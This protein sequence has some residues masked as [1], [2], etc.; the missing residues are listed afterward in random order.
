MSRPL[1]SIALV[2]GLSLAGPAQAETVTAA[3]AANFTAVAETLAE[4]F[5]EQTSHEVVLS[6]GS[7]GQLYAQIANAA[8]FDVFLAADE[9]RPGQAIAEGYA[10]AGTD[11]V[12]AVGRLV[13]YSPTI[14][15]EVGHTALE[16]DFQHLAIADPVAA[17]YGTAAVQV[18]EG[19]GLADTIAD[20]I[21][22]GENISQALQF[23]ESGN[24]ELGFVAASQVVGKP[25]QWMVPETLHAPIAQRAVLLEA[26]ADSQAAMAF[27]D[28]LQSPEGIT[29]IEAAGYGVP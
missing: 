21:V 4:R 18:L 13:L 16:G 3:V 26:G 22:T 20:R 5:S 15:V 28:Y 23:V 17:P 8:P 11:F 1:F 10:V 24:A 14:D 7:T 12:Y 9:I 25:F 19:L 27:L 6:F 29:I 2:V